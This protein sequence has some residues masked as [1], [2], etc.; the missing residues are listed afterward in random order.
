LLTEILKGDL[1]AFTSRD[2]AAAVAEHDAVA[3]RAARR[4][5]RYSGLAIGSVVNLVD[6]AIVVIGG[7]IAEALGER[8]VQWAAEVARRQMLSDAQR[9]TP[10]VASALGDD[11][12]LLG[13]ALTAFDGLAN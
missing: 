13:A 10:I 4:S 1:L 7:G 8:Y 12:G 9:A 2:L 6:P 5:A 11:A 3:I